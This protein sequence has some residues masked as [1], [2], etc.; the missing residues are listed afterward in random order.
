MKKILL[1]VLGLAAIAVAITSCRPMDKT[2]KAIGPVPTPNGTPQTFSLTL[3]AADY[4]LLPSGNYAKTSMNFASKTDAAASIPLILASKYPN[5]ADKSAATVTYAV[6]ALTL[7]LA[8]SVFSHVAYTLADPADYLKLPNNKY[9]DFSDSQILSWLPYQYPA[10][11]DNQLALLT[12]NYYA[13]GVTAPATLSFLYKNGAWMKIYTI[14]PAQYTAVGKGGTNNDFSTGDAALL[15]SYFNT[16]L[17]ADLAVAATAKP[18]DVQYVSYKYYVPKSGSGATA[19]PAANY[20]R[21]L[22]LVF[23]GTNWLAQSLPATLAFVKTNGTWVADNTVTFTLSAADYTFIA[24]TGIGSAAASSNLKQFGDFSL[25]GTSAW[26]DDQINAGL[27]ALL[28][29]KYP[30]AAVNQKFVLTYAAYNGG[31]INVTKTFVYNGST[32]VKQ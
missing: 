3:A 10:P 11:A 2:Y 19:V 12:F 23:D 21:V 22:P 15:P 26:T 8:D 24:G 25:S 29:N 13:N 32:F 17:K 1:N 28:A 4:A 30:G 6:P 5:Y 16:L 31:T 14:T 27:I 18:G 7:K 20:Q 9:D